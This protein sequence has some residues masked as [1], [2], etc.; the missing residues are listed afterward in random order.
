MTG[1]PKFVSSQI[2][3]IRHVQH[4]QIS[5][6]SSQSPGAIARHIARLA[7]DDYTLKRLELIFGVESYHW[8]GL[9]LQEDLEHLQRLISELIRSS[10]VIN[11]IAA[12]KVLHNIDVVLTNTD[13]RDDRHTL[14]DLF[15]PLVQAVTTAKAWSCGG[16]TYQ[17]SYGKTGNEEH[18]WTWH[19]SPPVIKRL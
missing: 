5:V 8:A 19:L 3:V 6:R 7:N 9:S 11:S 10:K 14:R 4:C 18:E 12:V 13:V 16:A 15:E 2:P 1:L 17:C